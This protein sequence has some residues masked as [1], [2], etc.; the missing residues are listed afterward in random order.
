[1]IVIIIHNKIIIMK[2]MDRMMEV[3][4]YLYIVINVLNIRKLLNK[5]INVI[6][7]YVKI[8]QIMIMIYY[9]WIV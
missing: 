7:L 3:N 8:I 5:I 4:K 6:L 2:I 9:V 1:M